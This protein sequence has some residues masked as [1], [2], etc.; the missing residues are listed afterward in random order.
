M[1]RRGVGRRL[2]G[3]ER[4]G[5]RNLFEQLGPRRLR[6]FGR[7]EALALFHRGRL[8]GRGELDFQIC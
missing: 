6:V 7:R 3:R 1:S 5:P 8:D 4:V 2:A